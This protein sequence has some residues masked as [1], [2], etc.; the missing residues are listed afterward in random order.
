MTVK[1]ADMPLKVTELAPVKFSPEIVTE[2]PIGPEL[3]EKL[4][5]M[6]AG[7]GGAL[8]AGNTKSV[9]LCAGTVALKLVPLTEMSESLVIT[10][11]EV[12]CHA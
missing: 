4:L 11:A 7:V 3:G 2:A 12:N 5:M 8:E 9:I 6:G 10:F 1:A